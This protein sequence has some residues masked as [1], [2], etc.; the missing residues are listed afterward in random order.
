MVFEEL[1][2]SGIQ[3]KVGLATSESLTQ[4]LARTRHGKHIV[5]YLV[6]H[7]KTDGDRVGLVLESLEER[8]GTTEHVL[9]PE[10]FNELMRAHDK[11]ELCSMFLIFLN[12][13]NS[14]PIAKVLHELGCRHVIG[15]SGKVLDK[16]A[17]QFAKSLFRRLAHGKAVHEAFNMAKSHQRAHS[18]P[19]IV[20]TADMFVLL[21]EDAADID[22][23]GPS[24]FCMDLNSVLLR[25]GDE[26]EDASTYQSVTVPPQ[27]KN[28][29]GRSDDLRCLAHVFGRHRVCVVYGAKGIGKWTLGLEF[30]R[31][32]I[33]PGRAF[34]CGVVVV[35]T[36]AA[37]VES[38]TR[39]IKLEICQ[40][41]E[42]HVPRSPSGEQFPQI[43]QMP[44]A[45]ADDLREQVIAILK[46]LE[47]R[48]RYRL[49][50]VIRDRQGIVNSCGQVRALLGDI[51]DKTDRSHVL[52][53][54]SEPVRHVLPGQRGEK[55][56][57]C[58]LKGL[59]SQDAAKLLLKHCSRLLEPRDFPVAVGVSGA[60]AR[61]NA[62]CTRNIEVILTELEKH[63]IMRK[64]GGNPA[65]IFKV[66]VEQIVP[67]GQTLIQIAESLEGQH[68]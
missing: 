61:I 24:S 14:E 53:C 2:H 29:V 8:G 5:L 7:T 41:E 31:F 22:S 18:D 64:L 26:F 66:A 19:E 25:P 42:Q 65:S 40:L 13:C 4:C 27:T 54:S 56:I 46:Q 43:P 28:F 47:S 57:N 58:E 32:G 39:A 60:A 21:G 33:A 48:R 44:S 17:H 52:I 36:N 34:S 50:L 37:G 63:P 35:D 59:S 55:F 12:T 3:L 23:V 15:V 45:V 51:V 67:G 9:W 6:A 1:K 30:A 49:L 10:H 68:S 20:A 62:I 38:L 11:E 16:A